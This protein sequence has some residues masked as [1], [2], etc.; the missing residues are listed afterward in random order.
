MKDASSSSQGKTAT[1]DTLGSPRATSLAS[2]GIWD[3]YPRLGTCRPHSP[4]A[5]LRWLVTEVHEGYGRGHSE[6]TCAR[7]LG[8]GC[9]VAAGPGQPPFKL[10]DDVLRSSERREKWQ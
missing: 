7:Y 5:A 4:H 8:T 6:T 2:D 1:S 3:Y 10:Q 9:L